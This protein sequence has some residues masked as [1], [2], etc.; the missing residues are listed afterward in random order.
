MS[1]PGSEVPRE[2][3][4]ESWTYLPVLLEGEDPSSTRVML[5]SQDLVDS[6]MMDEVS[7]L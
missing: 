4:V 6:D 2:L 5:G 7:M 3:I 1:C